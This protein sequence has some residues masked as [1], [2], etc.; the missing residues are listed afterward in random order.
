MQFPGDEAT[1]HQNGA[2]EQRPADESAIVVR[3]LPHLYIAGEQ[4]LPGAVLR[5][6]QVESAWDELQTRR[7]RASRRMSTSR[8]AQFPTWVRI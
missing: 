5:E 6:Y 2:P 1:E 3:V 4:I 8:A 7:I